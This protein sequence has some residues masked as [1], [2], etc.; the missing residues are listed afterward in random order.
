MVKIRNKKPAK[1]IHQAWPF[2]NNPNY[3]V[4]A[5]IKEDGY[6][7]ITIKNISRGAKS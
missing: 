7:Q 1:C 4:G 2:M 5:L 3:E 6:W